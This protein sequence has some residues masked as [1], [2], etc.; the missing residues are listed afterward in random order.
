MPH[1]FTVLVPVYNRPVLVRETIDSVLAQSFTDYE[2]VI[3]DDGST[4]ETPEVLRSY[5]DRLKIIRQQ[6][7]GPEAAR[8]RAAAETDGE[9][10]VLLDSDDLLLPHSLATYDLII[11]HVNS[12]PV[13]IGAMAP[14]RTGEPLPNFS[15]GIVEIY[16]Y[17]DLFDRDH[18]VGTTCSQ[19]VAK[20]SAVEA[21]GAFRPQRTA[22][23][24]DTA[25]ILLALSTQ[26]P[27]IVVHA[28]VTIAYRLHAA[29]TIANLDY[30]VRTAPRL[31]ELE[32][33]GL[34]PGGSERRF[35]RWAYLGG[36]LWNWCRQALAA[37]QLK[38]A[39]KLLRQGAVMI[40]CGVARKV[41]KKFRAPRPPVRIPA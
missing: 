1:R 10:F 7:Q 21:T 35:P 29:N 8:H 20:R 31:I 16:R 6:N 2:L 37:R 9:Y 5:G 41:T 28:P 22:F 3:I 30:M 26:S 32:K 34:Y 25:D 39:F 11:R 24:F 40:A 38:L 18:P 15:S 4:D 23:P 14:Y 13:V 27:W 17:R 12:P 33:Q 36:V 19:I